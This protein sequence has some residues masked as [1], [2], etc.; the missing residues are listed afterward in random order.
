MGRP[1]KQT[2]KHE[3]TGRAPHPAIQSIVLQPL[4]WGELLL[5]GCLQVCWVPNRIHFGTTESQLLSKT[6]PQDIN[7]SGYVAK[8]S[9]PSIKYIFRNVAP[10]FKVD[11]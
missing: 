4:D 10:H 7:A 9:L 1:N 2:N 6:G 5:I 8:S 11:S 3:V